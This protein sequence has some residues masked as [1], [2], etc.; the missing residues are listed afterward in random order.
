MRL[1]RP[2]ARQQT[3]GKRPPDE[4]ADTLVE[5]ERDELVLE[6]AGDQVVVR[7][8]RRE[9]LEAPEVGDAQRFLIDAGRLRPA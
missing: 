3:G 9:P 1:R 4:H 7:L 2:R 6:L 8:Q 5:A